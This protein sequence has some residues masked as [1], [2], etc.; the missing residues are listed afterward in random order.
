M[1]FFK[2]QSPS[3]DYWTWTLLWK[4]NSIYFPLKTQND[5]NFCYFNSIEN[6]I[7]ACTWLKIAR[8]PMYM[9]LNHWIWV[10]MYI[11]HTFWR[12]FPWT[13][14]FVHQSKWWYMYNPDY[15]MITRLLQ[16]ISMSRNIARDVKNSFKIPRLISRSN[17]I[18]IF[19]RS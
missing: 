1:I 3:S 14:T 4:K 17:L 10:Y 19:R 9:G 16:N 8:K 15:R 11:V 2:N 7:W 5:V 12:V 18:C 6:R 13:C